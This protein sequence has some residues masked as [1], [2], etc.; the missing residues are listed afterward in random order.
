MS[1]E[2]YFSVDPNHIKKEREKARELRQ[3]QW[4]KQKIARGV[5]HYCEQKFDP[6]LLTM[7]HIVPLG[8]GGFSTK[9]NVVVSC[10]DCNTKKAHRIPTE[11]I[12]APQ[13]K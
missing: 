10:K 3:S 8:R 7:D 2:P 12:L 4:W 6:E 5:C 9:G 11:S 1:D 13:K